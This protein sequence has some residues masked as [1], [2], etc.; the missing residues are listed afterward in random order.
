[1]A[2]RPTIGE[3]RGS[4]PKAIQNANSTDEDPRSITLVLKELADHRMIEVRKLAVDCLTWVGEFGPVIRALGDAREKS[5]WNDHIDHLRLSVAQG[6]EAAAEVRAAFNVSQAN[7]GDSLYRM[8]WG[9]TPAQ[10]EAG[11]AGSLVEQ[12][13]HENLVYRVLSFWNLQQI[14]GGPHDVLSSGTHHGKAQAIDPAMAEA[15]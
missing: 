10:L 2:S 12:L 15:T 1:M 7:D 14:T 8:L 13:D 4:L 6:P 11:D 3:P 5:V 9:Y